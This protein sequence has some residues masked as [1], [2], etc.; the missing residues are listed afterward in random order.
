MKKTRLFLAA[1]LLTIGT[2]SAVTMSSC[3][4]DDVCPV[5]YT[6]K[7]CKTL[8]RDGFIGTWSGSDVCTSGKYDV[9]LTVGASSNEIKALVN[10][11]GGFGAAISITG[12][13]T[14]ENTLEFSSQDVGNGRTLA[15]K[16]VFTGNDMSFSYSVKGTIDNDQCNGT[17]TRQ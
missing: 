3:G 17:Y 7:D 9:T 8:V 13:V 16:M 1:S 12:E 4:K 14:S 5:G 15:G 2:F 10:N 6:G 11:P